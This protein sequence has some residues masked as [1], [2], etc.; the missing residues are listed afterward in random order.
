MADFR[1]TLCD[2]KVAAIT[3]DRASADLGGLVAV[4][5]RPELCARVGEI[6]HRLSL[7]VGE[8]RDLAAAHGGG[9]H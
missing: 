6:S 8:L 2:I 3:V 7:I 9:R 5:D 4:I 1:D